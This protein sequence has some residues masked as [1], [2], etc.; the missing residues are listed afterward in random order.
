M[1][2]IHQILAI[3]LFLLA[4]AEGKT[5]NCRARFKDNKFDYCTKFGA[6]ANGEVRVEWKSRLLNAAA[7]KAANTSTDNRP[8][9]AFIEFAVYSDQHW[10]DLQSAK[11]PSCDERRQKASQLHKIAVPTDGTWSIDFDHPHSK[12]HA[13]VKGG[14]RPHIFYFALLDCERNF[15]KTYNKGSLPRVL[16]EVTILNGG[17]HFSYE[18]T[19]LL[20]LHVYMSIG[21]SLLFALMI[22]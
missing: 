10:D 19:G 5:A 21:M 20:S 11:N 6:P 1:I 4:I 17:S 12:D 15:E 9:A 13:I 3:A 14:H 22:K 8:S 18:D 2:Q 16:T 7:F